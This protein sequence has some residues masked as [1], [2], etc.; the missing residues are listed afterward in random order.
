MTID[1]IKN[2]ICKWITTAGQTAVQIPSNAAAPHGKYFAVGVIHV[3][4]YGSLTQP[5]PK[6]PNEDVYRVA[7]YV[8]TVTVHEVAGNGDTLRNFRNDFLTEEFKDFVRGRL[9]TND[10]LDR[11]FSVWDVQDIQDETINDGDFFIQQYVLPFRVQFNDFIGYSRGPVESVNG[12]IGTET[13]EVTR[14]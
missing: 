3:S 2:S 10:G 1:D 7:Q 14:S 5:P 9:N 12:K 6:A 8:A 4:Q 13:F 11:A